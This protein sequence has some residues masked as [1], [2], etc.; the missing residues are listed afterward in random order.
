VPLAGVAAAGKA[1]GVGRSESQ[2]TDPDSRHTCTG[3]R[4]RV[5]VTP[6]FLSH[7]ILG[8]A[9]SG[10][11]RYALD[12]AH[13]LQ[14]PVAFVATAEAR[15]GDMAARIARHRAERPPGWLTIEEPLDLVG[16][17]RRAAGSAAL[18]L[19]DC[20]TLWIANR[21][22][23]GHTDAAMLGGARELADWLS[24]GSAPALL[25]SNEVGAGVV[26]PTADGVRFRDLLGQ[27]NQI[28]AARADRVT[29]MVAGIP[30]VIK[31]ESAPTLQPFGATRAEYPQAP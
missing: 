31:A 17:C 10:K 6:R 9:R 12:L 11:S 5:R 7:L 4:G 8:G 28:V 14:G 26:P 23:A 21:L 1:W 25:V 30:S 27:V 29:L 13:A 2:E 22:L 20:L 19:V 3:L 15:D 18:V 16:G 24:E